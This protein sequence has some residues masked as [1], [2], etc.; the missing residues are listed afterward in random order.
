MNNN[1]KVFFI[2][3]TIFLFV[4]IISFGDKLVSSCTLGSCKVSIDTLW[5]ESVSNHI[6][7]LDL[8]QFT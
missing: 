2:F 1:R 4:F 6:L 7:Q 8:I 5:L 3:Y